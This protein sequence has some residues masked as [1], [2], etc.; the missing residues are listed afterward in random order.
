VEQ[1]NLNNY[2]PAL[3]NFFCWL[4]KQDGSKPNHVSFNEFQQ[5]GSAKQLANGTN[6]KHLSFSKFKRK[7]YQ[8]HMKYRRLEIGNKNCIAGRTHIHMD[9][10]IGAFMLQIFFSPL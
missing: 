10:L 2:V 8:S 3:R 7:H 6:M 9:V 5:N 1:T 4:L